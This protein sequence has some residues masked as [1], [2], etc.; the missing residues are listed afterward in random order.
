MHA[1]I[2]IYD[3]LIT[4]VLGII[5]EKGMTFSFSAIY[6]LKFLSIFFS[7]FT[8][9]VIVFCFVLFHLFFFYLFFFFFL[10]GG[11]VIVCLLSHSYFFMQV[12]II[13][14]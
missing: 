9:E 12:M 13:H 2:Y 7:V 6:H 8:F 11:S 14:L 5:L 4:V 1:I 3:M 10:G